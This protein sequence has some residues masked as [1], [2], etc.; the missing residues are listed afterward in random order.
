[1]LDNAMG[2]MFLAEERG[3]AETAW[4]RTY[5]TFNFGK[6]QNEHKSSFGLLHVLNEE[7]LAGQKKLCFVAEDHFCIL[8][9]PT[10]GAISYSDQHG[11]SA[12]IEAGEALLCPVQKG[13]AFEIRNPYEKEL[14]NFLQLWFKTPAGTGAKL[15]KANFDLEQ[16]KNNLVPLFSM[17]ANKDENTMLEASIAKFDGRKEATITLQQ[18]GNKIFAFVLEGAFEVQ[19][20]LMEAKDGLGLWNTREVEMEALSNNALILIIEMS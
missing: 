4:F 18:P 14:V 19:Y 13:T 11:N 17:R 1:M 6:F 3:Y 15:Q 20:R 5:N 8:L 16:N 12:L 10:V 2:K 7:T 9:L